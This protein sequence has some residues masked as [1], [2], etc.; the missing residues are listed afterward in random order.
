ME[1]IKALL[2]TQD[3]WEGG[4]IQD[5]PESG[6]ITAAPQFQDNLEAIL[7]LCEGEQPLV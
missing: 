3:D 6:L 4:A 5:G 1:D 7:K 2:L